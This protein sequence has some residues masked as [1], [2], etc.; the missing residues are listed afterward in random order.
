[1]RMRP[2]PVKPQI[3]YLYIAPEDLA[4][5]IDAWSALLHWPKP[6]LEECVRTVANGG[7][8]LI[9]DMPGVIIF[10]APTYRETPFGEILSIPSEAPHEP[11]PPATVRSMPVP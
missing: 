8:W 3:H 9:G 4:R 7:T 10:T 11:D 2:K 5:Q 6:I 1:M